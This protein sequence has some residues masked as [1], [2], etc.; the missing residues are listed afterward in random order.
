MVTTTTAEALYQ[1]VRQ[2]GLTR[3]QARRLLPTWWSPELER[4]AQGVAE[5]AMHLARRLS[6]QLGPLV[7]GRVVPQGAVRDVAFKHHARADPESLAAS[8]YIAA[9]LAQCIAATTAVP[10]R[11]FPE[12]AAALCDEIRLRSSTGTIDF[13]AVVSACWHHGV[14]VIP[15]PHLPVGLRK[16]D[17]AVLGAADRPVIVVARRKSS[18]AWLSFIVAH[19]LAHVVLGHVRPGVSIVDVSLQDMSTYASESATD[20]QEGE[21]DALALRLLGDGVADTLIA[22]W[23][24]NWGPAQ[25]AAASRLAARAHRLEAG[26]L[27]LR[28]GF[29]HQ[30]WPEAV[31]ALGFLSEDLDAEGELLAQLKRNVDLDRV[32]DDLQD[33]VA[34]ITGW[35]RVA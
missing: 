1:T 28:H 8:S 14:P 2:I 15:L 18:R 25:I 4:G 33:M 34:Q 10:Y 16:M 3:A 9:A 19:E 21:A 24:P 7:E 27:A 6:L 13:Q 30:R 31:S 23:L 26:H 11:P 17:G 29:R 32:A 12:S 35:G 5:L 22:N 20:R